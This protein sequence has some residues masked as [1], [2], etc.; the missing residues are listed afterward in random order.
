M[1]ILTLQRWNYFF[2][3]NKFQKENFITVMVV[4]KKGA[5]RLFATGAYD[6]VVYTGGGS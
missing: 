1:K 6:L 4:A 5:A 3:K 2:N